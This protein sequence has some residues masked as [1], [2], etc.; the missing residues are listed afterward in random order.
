MGRRGARRDSQL[1]PGDRSTCG[2]LAPSVTP[3]ARPSLHWHRGPSGRW[4]RV[5][6]DPFMCRANR[7]LETSERCLRV[8]L[9]LPAESGVS[10]R[11]QQQKPC[12]TCGFYLK[13]TDLTRLSPA[14]SVA[15]LK[16]RGVGGGEASVA[17]SPLC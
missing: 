2:L 10:L 13:L 1:L 4:A 17:V 7:S 11:L 6:H 14:D 8:S 15:S 3:S 5:L 9:S 12:S 16:G